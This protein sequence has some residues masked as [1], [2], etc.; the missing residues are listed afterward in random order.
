MRTYT[1]TELIASIRQYSDSEKTLFVTDAEIT[2]Y[3]DRSNCELYD[4]ITSK[5]ED[6][7]TKV[8][9][10][11]PLVSGTEFYSLPNDFYKLTGVDHSVN[12]TTD[13]HTVRRLN[14]NERNTKVRGYYATNYNQVLRYHLQNDQIRISPA[15]AISGSIR[16]WYIPTCAKVTTGSDTIDGKNGWD[17]YIIQSCCAKIKI[18]QELDPSAYLQE[19]ERQM[20]RIIKMAQ[21]YD[22]GVA[23]RVTDIDIMNNDLLYPF[24]DL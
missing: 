2:S 18:K 22:A 12:G 3:I 13:W 21:Q 9:P 5:Y 6:Y 8:G 19:K 4:A 11:V 10:T 17:E 23:E 7:F 24:M 20:Q 1:V 15:D 14:F 16:T